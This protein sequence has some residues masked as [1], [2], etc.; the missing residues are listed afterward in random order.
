M[1]YFHKDELQAHFEEIKMESPP[2]ELFAPENTDD[3]IG[4]EHN[5][6]QNNEQYLVN[7]EDFNIPDDMHDVGVHQLPAFMPRLVNPLNELLQAA[8]PLN[9][10]IAE[11]F[12]FNEANNQGDAPGRRNKCGQLKLKF[13][14]Y[15]SQV[16]GQ[17]TLYRPLGPWK[18]WILLTH[19]IIQTVASFVL[20]M[21][22]IN[23]RHSKQFPY[24]H[25][26]ELNQKIES[27][28]WPFIFFYCMVIPI[29]IMQGH[30]MFVFCVKERMFRK[31]DILKWPIVLFSI[32]FHLQYV[33]I[34]LMLGFSNFKYNV[35]LRNVNYIRAIL[36]TVLFVCLLPLISIVYY[37]RNDFK[38]STTDPSIL[39]AISYTQ[40]TIVCMTMNL[41]FDA[42]IIYNHRG[43]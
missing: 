17:C 30:I 29:S 41:L 21:L 15:V 40:A 24:Q 16:N 33:I 14:R 10:D 25:K 2:Q 22:L 35:W 43:T 5:I 1:R 38:G 31:K 28:L 23:L 27:V 39:S 37:K 20:L 42:N 18:F 32:P 26:P 4:I 19:S 11:P 3:V 9:N 36:N 12:L 8:A 34:P 13:K 7:L 6:A